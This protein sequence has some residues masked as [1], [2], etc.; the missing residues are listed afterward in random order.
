MS[1]HIGGLLLLTLL[2]TPF[3]KAQTTLTLRFL[4]K[5][6]ASETGL[7]DTLDEYVGKFVVPALERQT[8]RRRR[9]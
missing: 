8:F 9:S 5:S 4:P 2:S 6:T 7:P 1:T 3:V